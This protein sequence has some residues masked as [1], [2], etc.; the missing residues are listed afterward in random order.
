MKATDVH[1]PTPPLGKHIRSAV[2]NRGVVLA[3]YEHRLLYSPP[4]S[5]LNKIYGY[6]KNVQKILKDATRFINTLATP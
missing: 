1:L 5:R 4:P 2:I 6:Y 3:L